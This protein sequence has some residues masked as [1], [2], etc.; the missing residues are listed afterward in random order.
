MEIKMQ[1]T[2]QYLDSP[3]FANQ[4]GT[5]INATVKFAE[6]PMEVPFTA[7]P[8]DEFAH[9]RDLY[10]RLMAGEFGNVAPYVPPAESVIASDIRYMRNEFLK[11]SDYIEYP[12]FRADKTSEFLAAWDSYRAALRNVTAQAG[13]PYQVEWPVPP[14]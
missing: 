2:F 12:S 8:H 10:A 5:A 7:T 3:V 9:G 1:R 11:E 4:E 13:F 6:L 14:V